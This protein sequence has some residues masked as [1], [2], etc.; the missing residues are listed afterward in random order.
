MLGRLMDT[1]LKR[2]RQ[3]AGKTLADVASFASLTVASLSRIENG[4]QR[5]SAESAEKIAQFFAGE[6]SEVEILYPER[7]STAE[8]RK[9]G[10]AA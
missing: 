8:K 2:V 4:I 3:T 7:Y 1:P 5:P 6:I 9:R 10:R